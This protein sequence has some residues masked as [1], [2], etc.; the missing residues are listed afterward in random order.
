MVDS[1]PLATHPLQWG[2]TL[3]VEIEARQSPRCVSALL[4]ASMGLDVGR[5]DRA[6]RRA[7][8][9][10]PRQA[11]MGLD[12]GRRDRVSSSFDKWPSSHRQLQWGST[13]VV[14]I[15]GSPLVS[16]IR[17]GWPMAASMGLDVG[18]RD[19]DD[20]ALIRSAEEAAE[21]QWGSTLVVE[22]EFAEDYDLSAA[23]TLQWGSTLVVEIESAMPDRRGF[24]DSPA[25]MG[26][27]VGRRDRAQ[28]NPGR[29]QLFRG[30]SMGL[31]VGRR[32]RG[33]TLRLRL[34]HPS[35]L[36]WGSTLVVEIEG[37]PESA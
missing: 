17:T 2:S 29:F 1:T 13:L 14:E 9:F 5:R 28:R 12:V 11:S 25:S 6:G 18:R 24:T 10:P 15:E 36:Q 3:V 7:P 27:D 22:I 16:L 37:S 30:A 35:E 33:E 20:P 32:D 19:R 31:D 23:T 34:C 21:L 4:D 8:R 26:L